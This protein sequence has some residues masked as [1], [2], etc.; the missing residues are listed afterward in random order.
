MFKMWH[1]K[2][3]LGFC[4]GWDTRQASGKRTGTLN[5]QAAVART[6]A[7]ARLLDAMYHILRVRR[8]SAS[9]GSVH[10]LAQ[11]RVRFW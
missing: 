2:Q 4:R 5:V 8:H 3:G 7:V 1:A 6:L 9:S 10:A 11:A